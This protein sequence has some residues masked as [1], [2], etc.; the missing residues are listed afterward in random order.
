MFIDFF[1]Q[2]LLNEPVK[3]MIHTYI[4]WRFRLVIML[5]LQFSPSGFGC[6]KAF[7]ESNFNTL[8]VFDRAVVV[9]GH[10]L[11]PVH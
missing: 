8:S 11:L 4:R 7:A 1:W 10:P 6:D 3:N 5:T 2:N 9:V